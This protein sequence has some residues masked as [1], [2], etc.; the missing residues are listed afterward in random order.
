MQIGRTTLG[1]GGIGLVLAGLATGWMVTGHAA[2]QSSP[3]SVVVVA[4]SPGPNEWNSQPISSVWVA[5]SAGN[6]RFC[7][8]SHSSPAP[9]CTKP[10]VM[11]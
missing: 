1:L 3:Q 2:A 11:D 9:T 6:I 10:A 4:M 7:R 5:D 8:Y